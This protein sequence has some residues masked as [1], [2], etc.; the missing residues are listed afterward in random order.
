[1]I[2]SMTGFGRGE[3]SNDNYKVTV[4]IKS[5][6]HRYCDISVHLPRKLNFFETSIRKQIKETVNRG[7]IDVFVA[8]EDTSRENTGI[9]YNKNIADAYIRGIRQLSEN[10][11]LDNTVNAYQISRFPE[12]FTTEDPELDEELIGTLVSDAIADAG[13]QLVASRAAEG[14]KLSAD[15]M[16][17]LDALLDVVDEIEKRGPEV[18]S[19]HRNK[20][21]EKVEELLGNT[22]LDESVLATE[23]VIYADKICVDEEIVRLRTH[24]LHMKDTLHAGDHIG[25]KLDFLTQEMNREAN[26]ILSKSTD[27]S[28]SDDGIA[29]KTEIEKIREQIQNIE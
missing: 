5:V 6:N 24:I 27:I 18:L 23:L 20:L 19:E 13:R 12:V 14:A 28:I 16:Q 4:E 11:M 1:M 26:T 7:K 8:F 25:R 15:L 21:R 29:L 2:Q 9:H 10:F 3:A 22:H 17:K